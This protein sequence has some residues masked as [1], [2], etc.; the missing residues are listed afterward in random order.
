MEH[1]KENNI[2]RI[3]K[4]YLDT[5]LESYFEQCEHYD[6]DNYVDRDDGPNSY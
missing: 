1:I 2:E 5:D 6:H 3:V 4:E